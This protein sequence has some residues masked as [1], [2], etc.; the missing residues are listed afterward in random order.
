MKVKAEGKELI[1]ESEDGSIAIIP[2]KDSERIR[3]LAELDTEE[4]NAAIS[5]YIAGLP[6][7]TDYVKRGIFVRKEGYLCLN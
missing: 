5:E 2:V 6:I 1:M 3:D 4:S 7:E